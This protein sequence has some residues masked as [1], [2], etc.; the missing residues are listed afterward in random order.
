LAVATTLTAAPT[1]QEIRAVASAPGALTA[2]FR[3]AKMPP[4]RHVLLKPGGS[5]HAFGDM[6]TTPEL[7]EEL[8]KDTLPTGPYRRVSDRGEPTSPKVATPTLPRISTPALALEPQGPSSSGVSVQ[9]T[10]K[11][12]DQLWEPSGASDGN[13]VFMTGNW[14][15]DFSSDGQH[16]TPVNPNELNPSFCC[17]QV[18]QYAPSVNRFFWLVQGN[19]NSSNENV[20]VL[21]ESSPAS[22]QQSKGLSWTYWTFSSSSLGYPG[23]WF[24]YPD[25]SVGASDLIWTTNLI[26]SGGSLIFRL[27]LA[28][29]A[30]D[31]GYTFQWFFDNDQMRPAQDTGSTTYFGGLIDSSTLRFYSWPEGQAGIGWVDLAVPTIAQTNWSLKLPNGNEWLDPTIAHTKLNSSLQ[32]ATVAGNDAYFAWSAGRDVNGQQTWPEPH[33][34]IAVV[35][36]TTGTLDHMDYLWSSD[37][38]W[39]WPALTTD[40]AG[41]VGV[42]AV[43][44]GGSLYGFPVVGILTGNAQYVY[45]TQGVNGVDTAGGHYLTVRPLYPEDNCFAGFVYDQ[46]PIGVQ[47]NPEYSIFGRSDQLCNHT[48]ATPTPGNGI[49]APPAKLDPNAD[50]PASLAAGPGGALYLTW[51]RKGNPDDDM[52]C[53]IPAGGTCTSP[54]RLS[55]PGSTLEDETD[56]PFPVVAPNG[57]VYVVAG[58]FIRDDVVVWASTNAGT[59]FGAPMVVPSGSFTNMTDVGDVVLSRTTYA[60]ESGGANDSFL[61]ATDHVGLGF[62]L[63]GASQTSGTTSFTFPGSKGIDLSDVDASSLALDAQGDPVESFVLRTVPRIGFYRYSGSG[64]I[65]SPSSWDGPTLVT[66]GYVARLAGG[67]AGLFL[68][69][70]DRP[71]IGSGQLDVDIRKYDPA[72]DSFGAPTTLAHVP[73]STEYDGGALYEDPVTGEVVVDWPGD[74][75]AG[76]AGGAVWTS[77]D[78]G[79]VWSGPISLSGSSPIVSG[80]TAL[81]SP[82][83]GYAVLDNSRLVL[84]TSGQAFVTY[85]DAGGLEVANLGKIG[86]GAPKDR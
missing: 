27:P 43:F 86:T 5:G 39:A 29:L 13:T 22:L 57:A 21:G 23:Q 59:S 42:A 78:G 74:A 35:N 54:R 2:N 64:P 28:Q 12:N 10:V 4:G 49:G 33:I 14:D 41:D 62:G 50:S 80:P 75:A 8:D 69:S 60:G 19:P 38:A 58:R 81:E 45:V 11:L 51:L 32:S 25:L 34:E 37:H 53:R 72:T 52:F 3:Q 7:N 48:V 68:L 79:S 30:N 77:S 16:F 65:T 56:Q 18:V 20:D 71:T 1:S 55:L 70:Q 46:Y 47:N 63:V 6:F 44:G 83:G 40:G 31:Q 61:M 84:T 36:I 66:D 76:P 15:A 82:P 73:T 24:D 26:G 17:D 85:R 9:S 67:P